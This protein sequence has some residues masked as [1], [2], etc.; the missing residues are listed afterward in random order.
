V[1]TVERTSEEC[2]A[3]IPGA[4]RAALARPLHACDLVKFARARP[5]AASRGALIDDAA[6]FV[7][8]AAR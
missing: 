4:H 3:A 1:R 6:A 8:G 2:A 5:D 7:R